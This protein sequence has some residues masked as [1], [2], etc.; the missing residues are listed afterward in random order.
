MVQ[1]SQPEHPLIAALRRGN[2]LE[3]LEQEMQERARMGY[4]PSAELMVVEVRGEAGTV[5]HDLRRA[6][7]GEVDIMGPAS[8]FRAQRWLIQGR[9][10]GGYKLA[11]RPLVQR[12]RDGGATVRID[13]DPV[14]L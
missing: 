2:P 9:G 7:D 11:L 10:L 6:A 13:V 5:E 1:T 8:S 14:D 12:W 3:Y 4:P